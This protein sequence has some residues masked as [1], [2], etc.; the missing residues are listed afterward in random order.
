MWYQTQ[1]QIQS[2]QIT[3][4]ICS[5][6]LNIQLWVN[7]WLIYS[8]DMFKTLINLFILSC[9][10]SKR[11][12]KSQ[13]V[14]NRHWSDVANTVLR[15]VLPNQAFFITRPCVP[16]FPFPVLFFSNICM[17]SALMTAGKCV[18][19]NHLRQL[20]MAACCMDHYRVGISWRPY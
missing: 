16:L 7:H 20:W 13:A 18:T 17:F 3:Q 14:M 10:E 4:S 19:Q 1:P 8:N 11:I 5:T 2:D 15:P 12:I 9:D 6:T